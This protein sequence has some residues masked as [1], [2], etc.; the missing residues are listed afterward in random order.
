MV[1]RREGKGGGVAKVHAEKMKSGWSEMGNVGG[2]DA[3]RTTERR[4]WEE[5][6]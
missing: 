3:V 2:G 6:R 1:K 4:A 5:A